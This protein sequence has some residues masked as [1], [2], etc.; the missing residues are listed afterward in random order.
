MGATP[1][2]LLAVGY[3]GRQAPNWPATAG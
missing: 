3:L 2:F 1:L